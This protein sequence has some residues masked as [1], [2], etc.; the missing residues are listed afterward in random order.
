MIIRYNVF[1]HAR[2]AAIARMMFI[3]PRN[4]IRKLNV[5]TELNFTDNRDSGNDVG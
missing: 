4:L 2:T 1:Y 5:R 3:A